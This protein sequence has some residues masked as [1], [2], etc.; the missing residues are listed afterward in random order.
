MTCDETRMI[1]YPCNAARSVAREMI[2][3]PAPK[4]TD[5]TAGMVVLTSVAG[6]SSC[7]GVALTVDTMESVDMLVEVDAPVGVCAVAV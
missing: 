4:G 2:T 5:T 1:T 3:R 7:D 6:L